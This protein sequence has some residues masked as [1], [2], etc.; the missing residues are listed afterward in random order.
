MGSSYRRAFE[1]LGHEV[2]I[3]DPEKILMDSPFWRNRVTRRLF[4]R[5]I[6]SR[7]NR[8]WLPSLLEE[9]CDVIWIG[10]GAWAL[11]FLWRELRRA[12]PDILTVC[13]NA[14]NPIVTYSRGGNRP[15]V[16]A[17]I[18][19]FDLYCTYNTGI[20]DALKEA[21]AWNVAR[22]PFAWDPAIHPQDGF[23]EAEYDLIFIGG[24][25]AY[26]EKWLTEILTEARDRNWRAAVFGPWSRVTDPL[27]REALQPRPVFG[28]ELAEHINKSNLA[29]N[30]LRIQNEGTHN[31]RTFEIPGSGGLMASQHSPEQ[32]SVFPDGEAGIY[33]SNAREAVEKIDALLKDREKLRS[34]KETARS[35]VARHTY[36]HRAETLITKAKQIHAHRPR[37]R[38][39]IFATHPIQYQ[40]PI[41]QALAAH[42]DIDLRV[43][44]TSLRG[45]EKSF[46]P[47]FN[48]AFSWDV[49]LLD[50]YEWKVLEEKPRIRRSRGNYLGSFPDLF[51]EISPGRFDAFLIPGHH[52]RCYIQA[53]RA[54]IRSKTPLI[55]RGEGRIIPDA[56]PLKQLVKRTLMRRFLR[57]FS[58]ALVIGERNREFCSW[59]GIPENKMF[60]APY[61]VDNDFFAR[62][63][64]ELA[65]DREQ[66]RDQW[67]FQP[68]QVVFLFCGK[69][70]PKKRPDDLLM[71][72]ASLAQQCANG[73]GAKFG[74]LF[75][76]SG[77][78]EDRLR[79]LARKS[80]V[81]VAFIGFVNQGEVS[82]GYAASDCLVL[83]SDYRESWGLVVNEA[84]ASGL[85]AIVSDH[86]GS[87]NDLVIDGKT[88]YQFPMG[89]I[90]ALAG[91]MRQILEDPENLRA[92]G[93]AAQERVS[94]Y[95]ISA[96]VDAA[97]RALESVRAANTKLTAS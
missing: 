33:F 55:I 41:F 7:F 53:W 57:E 93:A 27:L 87:A 12:R 17:S 63:A 32:E 21:G 44:Y 36:H 96:T 46:D 66:I 13:Y 4:E 67:G 74:L 61:C 78:Q 64:A 1:S 62:R 35:I 20:I 86:V 34:M 75:A 38:L 15:W 65:P 42:P 49:P 59:S 51:R 79:E 80:G 39:G 56:H 89:D 11:P 50:G 52:P 18:G 31:M 14:D 23:P 91:R 58:A 8:R 68:G 3:V 28:K 72:A 88:G 94:G 77:P 2:R 95:S 43:F 82:K 47:G 92:M 19:C 48:L 81:P 76:G 45:A 73:D 60:S 26:R 5:L 54:C 25:D 9:D 71:A 40:A 22:I 83:P 97:L 70:V 16:T 6:I 10:K 90:D 85:P 24:G 30:I 69:L 84:M 29:L 37:F